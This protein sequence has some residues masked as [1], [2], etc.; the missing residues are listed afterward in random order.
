MLRLQ[1]GGLYRPGDEGA[2]IDP[3]ACLPCGHEDER[4]ICTG[5][6]YPD[7]NQTYMF[8]TTYA[9]V[10]PYMALAAHVS[11]TFGPDPGGKLRASASGAMTA[12]AGYLN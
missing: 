3:I 10:V 5:A 9:D 12:P 6:K 11:G 2:A 8:D 7:K 4:R 1:L